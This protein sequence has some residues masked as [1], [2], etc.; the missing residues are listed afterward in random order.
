[1]AACRV[2]PYCEEQVGVSETNR[3]WDTSNILSDTGNKLMNN[4]LFLIWFF[5]VI[6]AADVLATTRN[7]ES[8][9]DSAYGKKLYCLLLLFVSSS[10]GFWV[11][12]VWHILATMETW[13]FVTFGPAS[14]C[15][16]SGHEVCCPC[17]F[18][19]DSINKEQWLK[20][21]S[22]STGKLYLRACYCVWLQ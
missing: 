5:F 10:R 2:W 9:A 8:A 3:N 13:P 21:S 11:R 17:C 22:Y 18:C 4:N 15:I 12:T 20:T 16:I 7:Q 1:M 14:G 19:I 6:C